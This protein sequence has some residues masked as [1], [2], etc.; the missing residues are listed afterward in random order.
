[1]LARL[2][3]CVA[4]VAV[5]LVGVTVSRV[6]ASSLGGQST[7]AALLLLGA[8][9]TVAAGALAFGV[10]RPRNDVVLLL[11][12]AAPVS[13]VGEWDV[14][15]VGSSMLFTLGLVLSQAAPPLVAWA[16]LV[17]P[18]RPLRGAGSVLVMASMTAG[19]MMVGLLPAL[20]F[21]PAANGC[22]G[23]PDNLLFARSEPEL[24]G[25]LSAAGLL[26][27]GI[28]LLATAAVGGLRLARAGGRN[29]LST[30][31]VPICA[32][33]YLCTAATLQLLGVSRGFVGTGPS[34]RLLWT[35]QTVSLL[36]LGLA[37]AWTAASTR[38]TRVRVAQLVV[39]QHQSAHMG[40]LRDVLARS[41][42]D[43]G[44][45][46]AYPVDPGRYV[47]TGGIDVQLPGRGA[48]EA[49]HLV[50]EGATVGVLV[51]RTGLLDSPG[52]IE[53]V[54][55]AARL[56][57]KHESVHAQLK[58]REQD[59]RSSRKRIV[60]AADEERHRLERDLHDGAQ[61][62]IVAMLLELR[63]VRSQAHTDPQAQQTLDEVAR[64]VRRAVDGLRTVAHGIHPAVL[65]DEGLAAAL[66]ALAEADEGPLVLER[67]PEHRLA[68]DVETAAYVLVTATAAKGA[69][70]VRITKQADRLV[71]DLVGSGLPDRLVDLEDRIGALNG[72]LRLRCENGAVELHVEIPCA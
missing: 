54:L 37:L 10:G 21:D 23:C 63:L 26:V 20:F 25:A 7:A 69:T 32:M 40:S 53:E 38:W 41:L 67:V 43:P 1:M 48:R 29:R 50:R 24:A 2:V 55:A 16:L 47:D 9:A 34:E 8:G 62:R 3:L 28:S 17:F 19:L 66:D 39:R 31:P 15:V 51:H 5:G 42:G 59:L 22:T 72:T 71:L 6:D 70:R 33:G 52:L 36:A 4:T 30:W 35:V 45:M 49:T 44:L 56:G 12:L 18:N 14:P 60:T 65:S 58:A 13:F 46:V 61:Q 57:L 11:L 27:G 64:L 68:S